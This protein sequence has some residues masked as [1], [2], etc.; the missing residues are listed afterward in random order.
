MDLQLDFSDTV[1]CDTTVKIIHFLV[2]SW[3]V[4]HYKAYFCM[5]VLDD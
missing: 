5:T 3:E 4:L 2:H 1:S